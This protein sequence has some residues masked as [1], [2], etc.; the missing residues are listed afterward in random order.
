MGTISQDAAK[1]RKKETS[2]QKRRRTKIAG[3][4][5]RKNMKN[6]ELNVLKW[7][8]H[9]A[10]RYV[11]ENYIQNAQ[12]K[13]SQVWISFRFLRFFSDFSSSNRPGF[14]DVSDL[15]YISLVFSFYPGAIPGTSGR[16]GTARHREPMKPRRQVWS[17]GSEPS[18][19]PT[20]QP[21][22]DN[23]GADRE[24]LQKYRTSARRSQSQNQF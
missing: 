11:I 8:I 1:R 6:D 24:Q 2:R 12:N 19:E 22:R 5:R 18:R 16:S 17:G 14:N 10:P 9:I 20:T 15:S 4:V 3:A 21:A 23:P 7:K 13:K